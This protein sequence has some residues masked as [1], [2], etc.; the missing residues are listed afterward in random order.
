[1]CIDRRFSRHAW[2]VTPEHARR[3][4]EE[5]RHFVIPIGTLSQLH[6]VA[7]ADVAYDRPSC[8]MF[9]GIVVLQLPDFQIVETRM[10]VRQTTF[11]YIPGLLSFRETPALLAAWKQV[12]HTPD[13]LFI[14]GHGLSHPRRF[15]LACHVGVLIDRPVIGCAKSRLIGTYEEPPPTRG[16]T[17]W[18]YDETGHIIG[19]VVRTRG[20]TRPVF[21]SVGHRIDLQEAVRVTLLC[22]KGYRLP[23]P[24]RQADQFVERIKRARRRTS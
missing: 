11:P 17:S 4:Q 8:R 13:V 23:E 21:V 6:L 18:L 7:G 16:S 1:M 5:L 3:L 2:R 10:A 20:G 24:I 9:A 15:G 22:S 12:S 14:D 19:A